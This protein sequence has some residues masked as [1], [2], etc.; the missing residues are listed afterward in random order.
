MVRQTGGHRRDQFQYAVGIK[1]IRYLVLPAQQALYSHN[2]LTLKK[3]YFITLAFLSMLASSS[4]QVVINEGSNRNYS[5]IADE[6]GEHPDWIELY[7]SGVMPVNLLNY[8]LTDDP[9]EPAKW[10]FPNITLQPGEF[11]TVFCSGKDRKPVSGFITVS[12]T[13]AFT[14]VVGWNTHTFATPFHWDGVSGILV[15][16]C[17]Y[18][19]AGYTSNSVFKQTATPFW[20]TVYSFMDGSPASCSSQY[21]YRAYLRPDLKM[22]GHIVGTGTI[23]NS[24]FDYPAPYGNWYWGARHQ[25]LILASELTAAGLSAGNITNLAFNVVSTDP[26]TVYDYIEISMKLVSYTEVPAT[27]DPVDPHNSLHTNFKISSSGE[28]VYLYSP[29]QVMQS[30][31]FVNCDDLDNSRGSHPDG[32]PDLYLFQVATPSATNNPSA[33]YTSYLQS[34][35]FSVPSGFYDDPVSVSIYDPNQGS[36]TIHYTTDGSDPSLSSPL[37]TGNPVGIAASA[38]LKARAFKQGILPSPATVSSY[39]IGVTHLT[40]VI[41]LATDNNNLYG[42]SGIFD[43]WWYDWEKT[44]YIE[45]FDSTRNLVFSQRAGIQIDGGWGGARANPQHSMRVKLD[46]GV[47]GDGPVNYPLIPDKPGRT[48]YSQFY[49]RNGSNQFLVYPYKDACEVKLLSAG[50]NNHYS[51]WR[52]VSVY[53]NGGYFGL[54][55]LREK[56]DAE[57]FETLEGADPGQ[58]DILSLSAWN[59]GVLHATEGSIEPFYSADSA[60][61][62]LDPADTSFWN[63]ADQYFDMTSYTDYIIGESWITNTDWPWNNIKIYRSDKTGYRWRFCLTDVELALL[64]NGWTDCYFDAIQYMMGYD[65]SNIFIHIWQKSM[66]NDQYRNYFINRYADVMN[67]AFDYEVI[68]PVETQMFDLTVAEMQNEYGRWGDPNNILGQMVNFH[69]NHSQFQFQISQRTAQVRNHIVSD[70]GLP[71]LVDLTLDVFPPGAGE[72]HISTITPGTY[73]WEGIYFNGVPVKIEAVAAPGYNFRHWRGNG[74]IADTL[75]A[76]FLDTLDVSA[77]NFTADFEEWAVPVPGP[78]ELALSVYPNP[79]SHVLHIRNDGN[80]SE[81]LHY[82]VM[83][84]SGRILDE[85]QLPGGKRESEIGI[86]SLPSSLY[87]LRLSNSR[88]MVKQFRFVKI[89]D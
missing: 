9:A 7:N 82:E 17:S 13:G 88:E 27:F 15:N 70:L 30:Q 89:G 4:A 39:L 43:N 3:I 79:A 87:I 23:Q 59:Y 6:N 78:E 29:A 51:A 74:L 11:R 48:V 31:L 84:M 38:V 71:N 68:S 37:Y 85:G 77:V 42:P 32:S 34:P 5:A 41:S 21:G 60:F 19:S 8:S 65:P 1:K 62:L 50:T 80:R 83:D 54:Y 67:T 76:V 40:P 35:A 53:I 18:S 28:A 10:Q 61:N 52:P 22:N 24:P 20:S 49:L 2:I 55:E 58:V 72:I 66:Q 75:N 56:F 81:P 25:M 73:P 45:Y 14:P 12:N 33:T 63:S 16:T 57:Y 44:A 36:S 86:G 46:D 47:L 64:P 26:N 69:N